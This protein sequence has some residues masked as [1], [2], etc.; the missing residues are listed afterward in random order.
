M[1]K[2]DVI[3]YMT[4]INNIVSK[5]FTKD[6]DE[7]YSVLTY[8]D[9][10][11]ELS[12]QYIFCYTNEVIKNNPMLKQNI[13]EQ[14]NQFVLCDIESFNINKCVAIKYCKKTNFNIYIKSLLNK[15][16]SEYKFYIFVCINKEFKKS[17][18]FFKIHH[19]Y[20]DSYKL[21]NM[22]TTPLYKKKEDNKLPIF[23][24]NTSF[25]LS[26]YYYII[27][28]IILTITNIMIL[29]KIVCA[30]Q[31]IEKQNNTP[32]DFIICKS[33][34]LH[35]IKQFAGK[36][37]ITVNDFLYA[38][39]IKTD[40]VYT[41][42]ERTIQSISSINVSNISQTNNMCPIFNLISNSYDNSSL[43][44]TVHST[45]N[46]YKYSLFV[47]M[48]S[49]AMN[50]CAPHL[51]IDILSQCYDNIINNSDYI[52]SNVVG[53]PTSKLNVKISNIN[54]LATVKNSEIVYNIISCDD[55]IS[56]ICSFKKGIIK[57][58]KFFKK[59]I[60]KAYNTLMD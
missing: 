46:C 15:K 55:K 14:N 56:I 3:Y 54:F 57:N 2:L 48:L 31:N 50:N 22:L 49:Y 23:K 25:L 33:F 6:K 45:F 8:I 51:N 5:I 44:K 59:C 35:K 26:I 10:D 43:F 58:K 39:M 37:N 53:P 9:I 1:Y 41:Q 11:A 4:I 40:N 52:Y 36:H 30:P 16:F 32:T 17:R 28:T 18:L 24:R 60:Y 13:V 29:C 20:V 19:A 7:S 47:P 34:P 21:M 12:K 42:Q 38:L 27:G